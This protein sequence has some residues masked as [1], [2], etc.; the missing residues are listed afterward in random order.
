MRRAIQRVKPDAVVHLGDHYDDGEAMQEEFPH[1]HFHIVPGNCDKYRLIGIRPET[2]CYVVCGVKLFM[3]HG[4][5]HHVKQT[6]Y[7]FLSDARAAGATAALYGHTHIADC[8]REEDGLWVLNPG[9]AGGYGGSVGLILTD[10]KQITDCRI[11]R[12]AELEEFV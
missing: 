7:R 6:L 5:N 10:G 1:M 9:T 12:Q 2:L 4:H 11:L 3:T 8:H